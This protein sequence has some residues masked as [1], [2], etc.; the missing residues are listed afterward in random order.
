MPSAADTQDRPGCS[1]ILWLFVKLPS[2]ILRVGHRELPVA[3][4]AA[5]EGGNR[6]FTHEAQLNFPT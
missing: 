5:V 1:A 6:F 3:H 2:V 4:I